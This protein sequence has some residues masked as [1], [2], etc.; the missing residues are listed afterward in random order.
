M[1][2]L[3]R[4]A[5]RTRHRARMQVPLGA[6]TPGGPALLRIPPLIG[7]WPRP[8][9]CALVGRAGTP[10]IAASPGPG[11]VAAVAQ[12]RA[13]CEKPWVADRQSRREAGAYGGGRLALAPALDRLWQAIAE[14]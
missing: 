12:D 5:D 9:R 6:S 2:F 14:V 11:L 10:N 1:F 13:G 4:A 3:D 8:A 7:P